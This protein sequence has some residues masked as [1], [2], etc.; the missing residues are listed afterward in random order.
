M[1]FIDNFIKVPHFRIVMDCLEYFQD[2][3]DFTAAII[4]AT[5]SYSFMDYEVIIPKV[6]DCTNCIME[7][8]L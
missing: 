6:T 5:P 1:A 3:T 8:L 2:S 4:P 7:T